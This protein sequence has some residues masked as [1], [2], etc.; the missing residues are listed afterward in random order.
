[1]KESSHVIHMNESR[2]TYERPVA[3]IKLGVAARRGARDASSGNMYIDIYIRICICIYVYMCMYIYRV[4]DV[5][6]GN[7]NVEIH[8]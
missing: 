2:P 6:S 5:S 4:R 1:M 8:I 7:I 3:A